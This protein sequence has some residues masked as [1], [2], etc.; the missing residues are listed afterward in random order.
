[1]QEIFLGERDD[2]LVVCGVRGGSKP[3]DLNSRSTKK[4]NAE[5]DEEE[6][7]EDCP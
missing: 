5:E 3:H 2:L 6:E 4:V 1:M 7:E